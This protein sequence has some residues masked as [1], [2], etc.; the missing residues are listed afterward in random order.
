MTAS[1]WYF[2]QP[3]DLKLGQ[4]DGQDKESQPKVI[5]SIFITFN[6]LQKICQKE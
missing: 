5:S 6:T 4:L 1:T 2:E 3:F